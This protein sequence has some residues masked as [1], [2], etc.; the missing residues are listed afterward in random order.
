MALVV[1]GAL[2]IIAGVVLAALSTIREGRL[3]EPPDAPSAETRAT[4]EPSGR[5]RRLNFKVDLPGILL[6]V[7]GVILL[8]LAGT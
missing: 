2:L 1:I 5:G 6:F 8:V 3:S 7:L 4:L